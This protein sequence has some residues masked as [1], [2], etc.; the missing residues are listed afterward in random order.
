MVAAPITP[1]PE[2]DDAPPDRRSPRESPGEGAKRS[3]VVPPPPAP[4]QRASGAACGP[5][6]RPPARDRR[7]RPPDARR[8]PGRSPPGPPRVASVRA[9]PVRDHTHAPPRAG[10]GRTP[11]RRRRR[12]GAGRRP[13]APGPRRPH[14]PHSRARGA[15]AGAPT[16]TARGGRGRPTP[17]CNTWRVLAL[18]GPDALDRLP[19]SR[20][21]PPRRPG[22]RSGVDPSGTTGIPGPGDSPQ[23]TPPTEGHHHVLTSTSSYSSSDSSTGLVTPKTSFTF[24][25]ISAITFGLS[26]RKSLAFSRP[27]PIRWSP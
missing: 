24:S 7:R 20:Q 16:E 2:A 26:F 1:L 9:A 3:T 22:K 27:C 17:D 5:P 12:R 21:I 10:R 23:I 14:R 11:E 18:G 6:P 25:S 19:L 13:I 8:G 4:A 15:T